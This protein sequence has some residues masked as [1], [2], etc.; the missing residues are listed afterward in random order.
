L[1]QLIINKIP[2]RNAGPVIVKLQDR[3]KYHTT[4][5]DTIIIYNNP[6]NKKAIPPTI[7]YFQDM[8]RTI[9]KT[10]V[11]ILCINNPMSICQKLN[12]EEK[13]SNDI[14]AKKNINIIDKILGVQYTNLLIFFPIIHNLLGVYFGFHFLTLT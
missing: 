1:N 11:G 8:I 5:R 14:N 9:N 2:I 3:A 7:S 13:T 10:N 12:L 4:D 6:A